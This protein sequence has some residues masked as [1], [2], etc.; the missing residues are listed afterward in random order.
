MKK[1]TLIGYMASGKTTIG[2]ALAKK[3]NVPFIDLDAYIA[4]KENLSITAIFDLKG[5]EHFR[6]TELA[7]LQ[8]LLQ[9]D[10][11]F[12]LSLGGGTPTVKNAMDIINKTAAVFT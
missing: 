12:V 9:Q 10:S 5:E 8:E 2:E 11:F 4:T 7:Y 6:K 1:I 3:L